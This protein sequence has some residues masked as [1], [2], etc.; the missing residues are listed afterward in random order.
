M[1]A[2]S[3]RP[4]AARLAD[5]LGDAYTIEGEIGRGGMGV[6]YRARDERLQRRVAIK[7]LPPELAFQQDIRQRFTREAQTAARLSHPHIV[8]IHSVGEGQN[9]VYFVM[10]YVDGESLAARIRRRG[11]LPIEEVRR[12]MKETADALGAAHALSVIHRDIKPDNILLE[13]TRGRVMVTD[14]GI[15]KALSTASG[16]TLTGVG[17][18]IGTPAF[19]S[20]EQAAGERNIDGRSDLYSLGVVTYQMLTGKLP[21]NAPSVAGIL[22]K[23]ITEA[24][25][26]IRRSRPDIPEDLALAVARCLEKDPESRWP[27]ADALRRALETRNV[28][29]YQPTAARRASPA[30]QRGS[31]AT[32][33]RSSSRVPD[34]RG[35]GNRPPGAGA[36]QLPRLP[37][38]PLSRSQR[39]EARR[40]REGLEIPDTG[41]PRIIQ[42]VR[43]QFASWAA[44]SAGCMGINVA[45]GLEHPWFLF[46]MFGM[47]IG[48]MRNYA[49]LW[50]AG[51]SWRDV[52][53]RPPAPDAVETTMIGGKAPR[54]LPVPNVDEYGSQLP[55]VLQVHGDRQAILKL[56]SK[57]PASER[58]MLPEIQQTVDALYSRATDLAKTLHAM[59]SNLDT[60]GLAA[61]DERIAGLSREPDDPERARRLNLLERQRQTISDLRGRRGQVAGHLESC[62]LAM[63]NVRF[64]LLRLRSAG[65]AAVLGDLTQATQQARSLSR[66]VDNVIAAA[67]EI[68]EVMK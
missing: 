8:P 33:G 3:D 39:R 18:A 68:R 7:V 53:K 27:T 14:F 35:R 50:S 60:D 19:M 25:P 17:V 52:L 12:I 4:L 44:V 24:A 16:A 46:P 22:M 30:G 21:F 28:G 20:P 40:D 62:V 57:L 2:P 10:G 15:A 54:Q 1:T 66:D 55:A 29:D 58:Q 61:I 63:Q 26:D 42:K 36:G 13:G 45:T 65:V 38:G 67:G 43:G 5:A 59:D 6:V 23:Q 64:D 9:L 41:E 37:D 31:G 11:P 34:L 47:G 56:M 32:F 49:T 48:L 51:Y